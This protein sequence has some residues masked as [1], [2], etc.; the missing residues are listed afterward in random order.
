M[1]L[2]VFLAKVDVKDSSSLFWN[3]L[4]KKKA[5]HAV[6]K[7]NKS[8]VKLLIPSDK[9]FGIFGFSTTLFSNICHLTNFIINQYS[10]NLCLM[11]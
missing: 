2:E 6:L 3:Q 5:L 4:K 10:S 11:L 7:L 1:K 9:L 8:I